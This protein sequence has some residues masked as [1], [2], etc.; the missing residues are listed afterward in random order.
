MCPPLPWDLFLRNKYKYMLQISGFFTFQIWNILLEL[1][2]GNI[3]ISIK[4]LEDH[5]HLTQI[6]P[7]Y[8]FD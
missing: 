4:H 5:F 7:V 6:L 3:F 2:K 8:M 1:K